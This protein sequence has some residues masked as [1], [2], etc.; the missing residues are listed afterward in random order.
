MFSG[1]WFLGKI[2]Y[3][4]WEYGNLFPAMLPLSVCSLKKS[5]STVR[6]G[7]DLND[8]TP[9]CFPNFFLYFYPKLYIFI[10]SYIILSPVFVILFFTFKPE[11]NNLSV[12]LTHLNN[13]SC[14]D[15]N[16]SLNFLFYA[17]TSFGETWVLINFKS[18]LIIESYKISKVD[19]K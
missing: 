10:I 9:S 2:T 12:T 16:I 17:E 18:I 11:E 3:R 6:V 4:N 13:S 19:E 7:Y 8:R 5:S 15:Q 14:S 1:R